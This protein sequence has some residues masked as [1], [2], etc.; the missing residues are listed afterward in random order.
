MAAIHLSSGRWFNALSISFEQHFLK[1]LIPLNPGLGHGFIILCVKLSN[2]AINLFNS[3]WPSDTICRHRTGSTL[4]QVMACW[5]TAPSHYLNQC[6]FIIS[7]VLWHSS[8]DIIKRR[9]KNTNQ[10]SKIENYS[11]K[12]TLRSHRG[13]WVK[14]GTSV[15]NAASS[16][17]DY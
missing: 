11:F 2:C 3:L 16:N 15:G 1:T 7:K 4:D 8:E 14:P 12:S 10:K 6:W 17:W 9:F 5:L 13:Q